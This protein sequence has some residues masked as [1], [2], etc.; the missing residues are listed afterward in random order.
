M[1]ET[2]AIIVNLG[3][4]VFGIR[5]IAGGTEVAFGGLRG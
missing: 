1:F 4:F 2:I 5:W 3:A